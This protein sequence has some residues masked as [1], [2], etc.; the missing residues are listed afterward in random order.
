MTPLRSW[1]RP[2]VACGAPSAS[3]GAS[4][5]VVAF[6]VCVSLVGSLCAAARASAQSTPP[7]ERVLVLDVTGDVIPPAVAAQATNLIAEGL[8]HNGALKVMTLQEL[9]DVAS[10]EKTKAILGCDTDEACIAEV[11]RS[12]QADVV[13][14]TS[15]GRV[16]GEMTVSLSLIEPAR[17]FVRAR[18]TA[19][20]E[21]V[22]DVPARARDL[23]VALLGGGSG[24]VRFA[25][26]DGEARSFAVL[27]LAAAGVDASVAKNL[28]QLLATEIKRVEGATV[29]GRDDVNAMIQLEK[30]KTTLGCGDDAQCLAELG[31]ALGVERLVVGTVG[32]LADSYV[33]SLRL[34]STR[35]VAVENR[36]TESYRGP[37]GELLRAV[38]HAGR[39]LLGIEASDAGVLATSANVEG[40]RVVLDGVE[41]G[42]LPLKPVEGLAPGR[43][44]V[45]V[46]AEHHIDFVGDV[47]VNPGEST[48]LYIEL[49]RTPDAWYESGMF[50]TATA[51]VSAV[52]LGAAAAG[53]GY[54][55]WDANRT[56][57]VSVEARLPAR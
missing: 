21:R 52:A 8:A 16:G 49:E 31:G 13:V 50:W 51:A 57:P 6:V 12:A 55:V 45:R 28:T 24:A 10:H 53:V 20:V 19:S 26:P 14:R 22:E 23:A 35:R 29:L 4:A 40:A 56:F 2:P 9:A 37:E 43:H 25:L 44:A 39:R 48:A 34:I 11:T 46:S 41:L 1:N 42:A 33:I 27:D 3:V 47:Y 30:D 15:A 32:K 54:L 18:E 7:P 17:A 36:I 38:R 5:P